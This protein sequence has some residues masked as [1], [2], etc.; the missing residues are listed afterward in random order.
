MTDS[1]DRKVLE[2]LRAAVA[3]EVGTNLYW[4]SDEELKLVKLPFGLANLDSILGGG[5]AF[6]RVTEIVGEYSAGK[7]LLAMFMMKRAIEEGHPAVFIDV[8]R[9]WTRE[10]AETLGLDTDKVLVSQ[11]PSGEAAINVLRALVKE[12]PPGVVVLDSIAALP[13]AAE[14]DN[15]VEQQFPGL[16]ARLVNKGLRLFTQENTG[17]WMII[18]IN[19]LRQK[20]GV[21]YGN[22][23]TLP[24][25]K[26][27]DFYS[28]QLLRVAR[29]GWIEEGEG[30]NKKRVGYKL[31]VTVEK[32]KQSRPFGR[33]EIP[34]YW[35]GDVDE[36]AGLVDQAIEVEIITREGSTNWYNFEDER[37]Y[38]MG[39]VREAF[40]ESEELADALKAALYSEKEIVD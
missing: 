10:W 28:W 29:A 35:T 24:G 37:W 4:G 18:L 26:G 36:V 7:T 12:S 6:N 21:V 15:P 19:Q 22:P 34:F 2:G 14:S 3:K 17:G 33:C 5:L 25:G 27:Q 32:S 31:R 13:P 16:Q 23:E 38:G 9:T 30:K 39:R 1:E 20:I 8:E 40:V 11:P